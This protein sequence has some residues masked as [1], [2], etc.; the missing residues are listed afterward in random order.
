MKKH[1]FFQDAR[2]GYR[3]SKDCD[4]FRG[5]FVWYLVY[6]AFAHLFVVAVCWVKGCNIVDESWGGPDGGGMGESC[7]RCNRG[8]RT[9]LY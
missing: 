3:W 2:V 9:P 7:S 1:Q 4:G 8:F 6:T 5:P